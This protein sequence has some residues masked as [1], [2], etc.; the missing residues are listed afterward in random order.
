MW[1]Q[2]R[3]SPEMSIRIPHQGITLI[4][5]LFAVFWKYLHKIYIISPLEPLHF[6]GSS[7]FLHVIFVVITPFLR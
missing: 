5:V 7:P 2:S 6:T 4:Y 3:F 1:D